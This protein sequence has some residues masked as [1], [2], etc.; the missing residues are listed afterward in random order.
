MCECSSGTLGLLPQSRT[1]GTNG[2]VIVT[3]L[4]EQPIHATGGPSPGR[5]CGSGCSAE[6][7][8]PRR[9]VIHRERV[10]G[11][12]RERIDRAAAVAALAVLDEAT[13]E[14]KRDVLRACAATALADSRLTDEEAGLLRAVSSS[15]GCPMP[16]LPVTGAEPAAAPR[17]LAALAAPAGSPAPPR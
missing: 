13:P 7:T 12:R 1:R 4:R 17:A 11:G 3:D 10:T 15:L 14:L 8:P 5:P 9:R 16:P 2:R 6:R